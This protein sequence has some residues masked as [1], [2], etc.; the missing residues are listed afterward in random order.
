MMISVGVFHPVAIAYKHVLLREHFFICGSSHA[1]IYTFRLDFQCRSFPQGLTKAGSAFSPSLYHVMF[2]NQQ[3]SDTA[4][5]IIRPSELE[6]AVI[7]PV[8]ESS[9]SNRTRKCSDWITPPQPC[10]KP[11]FELESRLV[12]QLPTTIALD[13]EHSRFSA[14]LIGVD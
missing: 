3:V 10:P 5:T 14:G 8:I 4:A 7:L 2:V 9:C 13:F 6:V 12:T 1:Q 11:P